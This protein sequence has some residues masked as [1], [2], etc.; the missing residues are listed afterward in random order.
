MAGLQA[1]IRNE[2]TLVVT[3][4]HTVPRIA[5]DL[6]GFAHMPPLLATAMLVAFVEHSCAQMVHPLLPDGQMTVGTHVD[7]SHTAA[8]P[9]GRTVT[10]EVE[11]TEIDGRALVFAVSCRDDAGPISTGSHRRA[12]IDVDR[13]MSRLG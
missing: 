7:L 5:L 9:V 13:F 11:L 1:G 4:Q 8:T 2:A 3:D 10:A 12:V 6:P